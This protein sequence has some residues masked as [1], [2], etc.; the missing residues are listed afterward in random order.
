MSLVLHLYGR[1]ICF[2]TNGIL[3][4]NFLRC[5]LRWHDILTEFYSSL[6]IERAIV[7]WGEM[8]PVP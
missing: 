6:V 1:Q 5:Y 3:L 8:D 4:R 7:I 2:V